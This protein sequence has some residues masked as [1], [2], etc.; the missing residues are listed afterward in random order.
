MDREDEGNIFYVGGQILESVDKLNYAI[1]I[2]Y[3]LYAGC[4]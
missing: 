3:K 4:P 1:I 2:M